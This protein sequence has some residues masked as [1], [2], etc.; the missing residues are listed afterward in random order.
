MDELICKTEE[1]AKEI[2]RSRGLLCKVVVLSN[3]KQ[4]RAD[5]N[6]VVRAVFLDQMTVE[7]TL[8]PFIMG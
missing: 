3:R 2:L 8:S 1:Q 4:E 7:L 6:L 5:T